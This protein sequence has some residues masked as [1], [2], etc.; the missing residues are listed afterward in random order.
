MQ[1]DDTTINPDCHPVEQE[2][3]ERLSSELRKNSTPSLAGFGD[4]PSSQKEQL[5]HNLKM[6]DVLRMTREDKIK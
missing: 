6:L 1:P 5:A 3:V 4:D 2:E